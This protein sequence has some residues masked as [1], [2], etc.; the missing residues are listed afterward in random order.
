MEQEMPPGDDGRE[1]PLS[2]VRSLCKSAIARAASAVR[3]H[4]LFVRVGWRPNIARLGCSN[5]RLRLLLLA[6][7]A[8]IALTTPSAAAA[9]TRS[10][11]ATYELKRCPG[12]IKVDRRRSSFARYRKL[13]CKRAREI[14]RTVESVSDGPYPDGYRWSTWHGATP[15]PKLFGGWLLSTY[16]S[17]DGGKSGVAV[18][19]F[20]PL[21][22]AWRD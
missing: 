3:E 2:R 6:L 22:D 14:V 4:R 13:S 9:K 11:A 10:I 18:V 19:L 12:K 16:Y 21:P 17:P 20:G 1:A 7:G 15:P 5:M 8:P